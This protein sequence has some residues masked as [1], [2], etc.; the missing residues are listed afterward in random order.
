MATKKKENIAKK[1]DDAKDKADK[2]VEKA[3]KTN[4]SSKWD[5]A[6]TERK[7]DQGRS[8]PPYTHLEV[9]DGAFPRY[10]KQAQTYYLSICVTSTPSL[11]RCLLMLRLGDLMKG[12]L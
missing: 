3:G 7:S 1:A 11:Y 8:T 12:V 6:H 5:N 4:W 2:K 10:D 9:A